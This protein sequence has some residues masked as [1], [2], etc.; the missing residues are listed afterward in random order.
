M[1]RAVVV[2]ALC[3]G[4]ALAQSFVPLGDLPGGAVV[5]IATGVSA[6][7]LIVVGMSRSASGNEAFRWTADEGMVGLGDFAG[8]V[9]RSA[10]LGISGDGQTI[11]GSGYDAHGVAAFRWTS[12][13]GLL[14]LAPYPE[15]EVIESSASGVS[16]DAGVIVGSYATAFGQHAFGW[17]P[18]LGAFQLGSIE[19]GFDSSVGFAVSAEGS[20]LVG[21]AETSTG[22]QPF[23]WTPGVGMTPL[24]HLPGSSGGGSARG[25][26]ADAQYIVGV[27]DN[28]QG[29]EEAF[30]WTAE[31]GMIGLGSLGPGESGA[32][33]VGGPLPR[34]VGT[35]ESGRGVPPPSEAFI[36][37]PDLGMVSLRQVLI[38]AGVTGL[39]GWLL[40]EARSI[41]ADGLFIVGSGIN[42]QGNTEG[43]LVQLPGPPE[44]IPDM[45]G[46]GQLNFF[47]VQRFLNL[48]S[49][50][51]P[52]ADLNNDGQLNFFDV[53]RFLNLFSAE[54]P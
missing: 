3:A 47:D 33:A 42:P 24:G 37:T 26:S 2:V 38:D 50:G 35:A 23:R 16:A 10:A 36:W 6:D 7:G 45:N 30:L 21:S 22:W 9:F 11:V 5:S 25:I 43:W 40:T 19:S 34:V 15:P 48:F 41:S 53:Q 54:C 51:D 46:D 14:D 44:C 29:Q 28:A 1:L 49:A 27:A 32:W 18:G 8:G 17:T 39:D 13:E 20:V 31:A 4:S 12:A 52:A